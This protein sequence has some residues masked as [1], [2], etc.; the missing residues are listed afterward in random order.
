[1]INKELN[2]IR[3]V[4]EILDKEA[5][6]VRH[7][8]LGDSNVMELQTLLNLQRISNDLQNKFFKIAN[9]DEDIA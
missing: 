4:I 2:D 1:M 8:I 6:I 9:N 5:N 3:I 7:S